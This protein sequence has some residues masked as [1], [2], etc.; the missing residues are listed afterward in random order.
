MDQDPHAPQPQHQPPVQPNYAPPPQAQAHAQ[1]P[2]AQQP[3]TPDWANPSPSAAPDGVIVQRSVIS[4]IFDTSFKTFVTPR[5]LK[6]IFWLGLAVVTIY[7]LV[8]LATMMSAGNGAIRVIALLVVP[9]I[10]A[11]MVLYLRVAIEV[12]VVF[13]RIE[14]NTRN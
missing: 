9:A 7:S 3:Q 10:W 4:E 13:F 11:L 12:I 5:V 14:E 1:Q 8:V 2:Q 6:G